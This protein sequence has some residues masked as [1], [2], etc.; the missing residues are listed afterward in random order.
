MIAPPAGPAPDGWTADEHD[1]LLG[2]GLLQNI[3]DE[4]V[5]ALLPAF[6]R[7]E[8]APDRVL[9]A[10][11]VADDGAVYVVLDGRLA[12]SR[13]GD[14][15]STLLA[16][17][18]PGDLCGEL[19]ALDPGPRTSTGRALAPTVVA[20]LERDQLLAWASGRPAVARQLFRVLARRL[21]RTND[22]V[23]DLVFVDVPG[24]V[25]HHL[26][27]L[28]RRFGERDGAAVVV[29][30]GL[31]QEQLA[32]LVGAARETVNKA[33]RNFESRGWIELR[34]RAFVVHDP[35]ALARRAAVGTPH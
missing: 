35:E 11:G 34:S 3:P 5:Q 30:H 16:V 22:A 6:R 29:P 7:A 9:F 4:D 8:L 24:R 19:T 26:L 2:S 28:Q 1:H 32:A 21:K 14:V 23:V 31:T 33:L 20:R 17:L 13:E 10:E 12:L 15:G 18:G 25:A 27:D